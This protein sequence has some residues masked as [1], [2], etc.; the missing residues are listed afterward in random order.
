MNYLRICF[1]PQEPVWKLG[2]LSHKGNQVI[3]ISWA[4]MQKPIDSGI[5]PEVIAIFNR[6]TTSVS[7]VNFAYPHFDDWMASLEKSE[8]KHFFDDNCSKVSDDRMPL[9]SL[10]I[11]TENPDMV[12][13]SLDSSGFASYDENQLM[14]LSA[15]G[16]DSPLITPQAL[17][18]LIENDWVESARHL[19]K[20]T[21]ILGFLRS[22]VDGNVLGFLSFQAAFQERF[23]LALQREAE[24]A[25]F[26]WRVEDE[27]SLLS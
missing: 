4:L 23:L 16:K 14:M 5:P 15:K 22:G 2:K 7:R 19:A 17:L 18:G 25:G 9:S 20:E 3:L 8:I 13:Y 1:T 11:S 24:Q 10:L 21:G 26:T 12:T 27:A 6:A